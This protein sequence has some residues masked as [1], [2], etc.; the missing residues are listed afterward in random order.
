MIFMCGKSPTLNQQRVSLFLSNQHD[1]NHSPRL[2]HHEKDAV[3]AEESQ[4]P[5]RNRI[6]P[7][8]LQVPCFGPG[9]IPQDQNSGQSCLGKERA[10]LNRA[11][12][13]NGEGFSQRPLCVF[14]PLRSISLRN[15][16]LTRA[17]LKQR[18]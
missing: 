18:V 9:I 7:E 3:L 6:G 4:F 2:V 5:L 11:H 14:A 13:V 12:A 8:R 10:S 1:S 16:L 17:I 15:K